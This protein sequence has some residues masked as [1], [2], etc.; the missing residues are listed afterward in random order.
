MGLW[1]RGGDA[2][3]PRPVAAAAGADQLRLG[4]DGFCLAAATSLLG[5]LIREGELQ[6][7]AV[8]AIR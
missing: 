5:G 2:A 1:R 3:A 7:G 6:N 4:S 8:Q